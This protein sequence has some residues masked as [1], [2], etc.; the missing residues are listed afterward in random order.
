MNSVFFTSM[1]ERLPAMRAVDVVLAALQMVFAQATLLGKNTPYRFLREDP[2][3][4]NV[5]ICDVD[6]RV[7]ATEN[8]AHRRIIQVSRSD[9]LPAEHHMHNLASGGFGD[10]ITLSDEGS[11][12]VNVQCESGTK[13]ESELLASLCYVL[14]KTLRSDLME[15]YNIYNLRFTAVSA[16]TLVNGVPGSPWVTTVVLLVQVQEQYS[17]ESTGTLM[18]RVQMDAIIAENIQRPVLTLDSSELPDVPEEVP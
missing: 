1:E 6:S 10:T 14:L 5:W 13:S 17:V 2:Q 4:S 15:T 8:D 7:R 16:P 12:N 3:K 11:V 18:N 9:Y